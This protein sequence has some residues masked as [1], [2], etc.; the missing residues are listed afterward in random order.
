M[1]EKNKVIIANNKRYYFNSNSS[2]NS[3]INNTIINKCK[4]SNK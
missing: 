1:I 2:Y 3:N 4:L